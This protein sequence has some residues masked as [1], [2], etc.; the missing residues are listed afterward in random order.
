MDGCTNA[1]GSIPIVEI[2]VATRKT[3]I[4]IATFG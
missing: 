3:A 1:I 2:N 4:H